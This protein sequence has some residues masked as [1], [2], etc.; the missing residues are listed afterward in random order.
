MLYLTDF[1]T[2]TDAEFDLHAQQARFWGWIFE[3]LLRLTADI[4]AGRFDTDA[5]ARIEAEALL[6]ET[7]SFYD[8]LLTA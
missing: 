4:R 3:M 2:N 7:T 5:R 1:D 6:A 8:S